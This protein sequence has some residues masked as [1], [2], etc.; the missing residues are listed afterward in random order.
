MQV[1]QDIISSDLVVEKDNEIIGVEVQSGTA[2]RTKQ[3]NEVDMKLEE[4]GGLDITGKKAKEARMVSI[5]KVLFAHVDAE[6]NVK[7]N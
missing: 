3:Q 5:D 7:I 2:K 1:N 4:V 6:G